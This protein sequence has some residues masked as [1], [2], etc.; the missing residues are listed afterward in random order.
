MNAR[1]EGVDDCMAR[2]VPT[3]LLHSR[4]CTWQGLLLQSYCIPA[5]SH[6]KDCSC[7]PIA[8]PPSM[9]VR[10][11]GAAKHMA[12]IAPAI[13]LH[14]RHPWRS[15]VQVPR[16]TGQGLLLQSFC[17]PAIHGGQMCRCR[18]AHGKDC[19][20]NPSA[21]PPLHTDVQ[22]PR[23]TWKCESGLAREPAQP[24]P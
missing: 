9:A 12:R 10:C 13:L 21:F 19:S 18:E 20:C 22:V 6:G 16:S 2:I 4:H 8:F 14:S 5:I 11:A 1:S 7:N 15:D 17:I 3:I 23:S 24:L